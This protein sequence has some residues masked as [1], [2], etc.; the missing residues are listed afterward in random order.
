M[1]PNLIKYVIHASP[2]L[3]PLKAI[4][5][6]YIIASNGIYVR[7]ENRFISAL[8]PVIPAPQGTV[9]GLYPLTPSI[10]LKVARMPT[11]LLGDVLKDARQMRTKSGQLNEALY[12]FHYGG[13]QVRVDRPQ[14]DASK[15]HVRTTGDGGPDVFLEI[16]SHGNMNAFWSGTDNRDER[17]FRI[18][19]VIG[20]LDLKPQ[21]RL[22]LGLYGYYYNI[23]QGLLFSGANQSPFTNL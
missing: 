19:G 10:K 15:T 11:S 3:P 21:I 9:R 16:H 12:R 14:Q 7:A 4:G 8:I 1:F 5:Y 6:E 18:Y 2:A 23:S 13:R 22:R 17:G 20:N